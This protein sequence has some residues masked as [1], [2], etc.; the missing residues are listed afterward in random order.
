VNLFGDLLLVVWMLGLAALYA[1]GF[2][3]IL[4]F[5]VTR[6]LRALRSEAARHAM[7]ATF[8]PAQAAV[9]ADPTQLVTWYRLA[10]AARR[11]D[12]HTFATLDAAAGGTFP[13][14]REQ[15]ERAHAKVSS[16]WLAWEQAHD[17]EYR[18]KAAAAEQDLGRVSGEAAALARARLD[19]IQHEK[20]ERYQQ[21]YE[22]YIRTAKA[23]Q[24][25]LE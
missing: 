3:A 13:F 10:Q 7:L 12:P 4:W 14:T 8:G 6:E 1:G 22:A 20:I 15:V 11:T 16:E 24:A 18:V 2:V 19:R 5:T 23:L 9:Q 17:E 25:L 21:R